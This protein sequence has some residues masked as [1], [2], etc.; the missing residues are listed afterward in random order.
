MASRAGN[1]RASFG[2]RR[3]VH[4]PQSAS[5]L[6][7]IAVALLLHAEASA[8]PDSSATGPARETLTAEDRTSASSGPTAIAK[9]C[10]LA[11]RP[12]A[13]R[14]KVVDAFPDLKVKVVDAFPDLKVKVVD[15]FPDSCGRWQRVDAFPD[16][17]V[18]FVDAFPDLTIR[19]VDA[20]PGLP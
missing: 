5:S 12:L 3:R 1:D 10:V 9:R 11:G 7:C 13:G 17:T 18:Q 8:D 4:P 19:E 14:V 6:C 16:F 2:A 15:A 20:F